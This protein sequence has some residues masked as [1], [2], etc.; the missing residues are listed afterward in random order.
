MSDDDVIDFSKARRALVAD[1]PARVLTRKRNDKRP[2]CEHR[3][4]RISM[5][6]AEAECAD[7]EAPLD[8]WTIL[9]SLATKYEHLWHGL[10]AA[11]SEAK[12]LREDIA[13]LKEQRAKLR[14]GM[15]K[16]SDRVSLEPTAEHRWRV[17]HGQRV[18]PWLAELD[19]RAL[20]NRHKGSRVEE[21][22]P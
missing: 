8:P 2:Y 1:D 16:G 17:H 20:S 19:A 15:P 12:R 6:E 7:C 3:H 10:A 9:R 4:F 5:T 14:R 11:R 13:M 22:K 18:S 21:H